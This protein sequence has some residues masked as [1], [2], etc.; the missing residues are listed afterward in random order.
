MITSNTMTA[1]RPVAACK[2]SAD[3]L[4]LSEPT[5]LTAMS[6]VIKTAINARPAPSATG[7]RWPLLAPV[8]L[9]VT[10]ASTRMHSR[11]S[12]KTRMPMSRNA[13]AGLVLGRIGSGAPCAATPCQTSIATT[14]RAAATTPMRK[15][16]FIRL[17]TYHMHAAVAGGEL[18]FFSGSRALRSLLRLAPVK[19]C[20]LRFCALVAIVFFGSLAKSVAQY[21]GATP[22]EGD[23]TAE[24]VRV[25]GA[26]PDERL[27]QQT[28]VGP[29]QQPEWTTTRTFGT[30]RVYVRPPGTIANSNFW[31]LEFKDG[32]DDHAFRHEIEFGLPYRL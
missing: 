13:T 24:V 8:M 5:I 21:A 30:S 3:M 10:A 1:S 25:T 12:R 32:E 15:A 18:L 7:R 9:A 26:T 14:K 6:H 31:T 23:A 29:N 20:I 11:P 22:F 27:S 17:G 28:L 19:T 4:L 16:A 2:S